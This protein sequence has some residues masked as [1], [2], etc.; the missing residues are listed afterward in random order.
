[1]AEPL[2]LTW[3]L[4][5]TAI[6]ANARLAMAQ[7]DAMIAR[8]HRARIV[9]AGAPVSWRG[10]RAEWIYLEELRQ[11]D[12]REDDFVAEGAL[13]MLIV[14]DELYRSGPPPERDPPRVLLSGHSGDERHGLADGYGAVAHARWFHQ[15]VDLIRVS[16][17]APSREEPL[18]SVQE[19]HVALTTAEMT[20]LV[21]SCDVL[22]GP[23]LREEPFGLAAAEAMAAGLACVVTSIPAFLSFDETRDYALFAPADNAVELGERLL[24]LLSDARLRD[25]LRQRGREVAEQWRAEKVG[26]RLERFFAEGRQPVR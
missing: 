4:E 5:D 24:E 11:Y 10:S 7:A 14:D 26:E 17:W 23:S 6:S 3:L 18:D 8:G 25:R 16:P 9:T 15:K 22:V 20:R 21:H 12:A 1:M 19:F 2:R 13:P